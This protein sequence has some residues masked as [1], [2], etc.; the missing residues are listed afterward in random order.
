[1]LIHLFGAPNGLCSSITESKHIKA[2]K[3]PWQ[4]SNR[5][6]ALLQ[7]LVMNQWLDKLAAAQADFKEWGM[8]NEIVDSHAKAQHM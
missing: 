2:V 3:Q 6:H 8:L 1:M 4:Q 5:Y 7:M